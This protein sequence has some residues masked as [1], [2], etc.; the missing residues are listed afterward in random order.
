MV[1]RIDRVP[2]RSQGWKIRDVMAVLV[3]RVNRYYREKESEELE[4]DTLRARGSAVGGYDREYRR[5]P[6]SEDD[7]ADDD[8]HWAPRDPYDPYAHGG[9]I[10]V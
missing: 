4:V 9:W 7:D 5:Y 1:E 3:E 6:Y 2:R 10:V 8:R